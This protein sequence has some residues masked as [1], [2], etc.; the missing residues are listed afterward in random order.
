M[1]LKYL[2]ATLALEIGLVARENDTLSTRLGR[3]ERLRLSH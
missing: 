1:G 3:S 2:F